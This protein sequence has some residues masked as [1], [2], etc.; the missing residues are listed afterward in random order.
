MTGGIGAA[1]DPRPTMELFFF[2]HRGFTAEA[3]RLL[4]RYG[5][6]RAHH[7]VLYFVA[8]HPGITVGELQAI[9]RVTKQSLARVLG[10]LRHRQYLAQRADVDDRRRRRLY[11]TEAAAALEQALTDRQ[12]ARL[13]RALGQVTAADASGFRAVLSAMI[14]DEEQ[15]GGARRSDGP[16]STATATVR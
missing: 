8:R 2:A 15:G 12:I 16:G 9:L 11:L 4:G 6:G 3:D 5:F 1:S 14:D 7:R 13:A 10:D